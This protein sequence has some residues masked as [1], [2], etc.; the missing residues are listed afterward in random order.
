MREVNGASQYKKMVKI[1]SVAVAL[2]IVVFFALY[3]NGAIGTTAENIWKDARVSQK[4]DIDWL[5]SMST[6]ENM[7]AM[8]FYSEQLDDYT[9]SI[10]LNRPGLS[11]GYFFRS[12]GSNGAIEDSIAEFHI[13]GCTDLAFISMNKQQVCKAEYDYDNG[14]GETLAGTYYIDSM[15]P[16]S[17]ILP[18]K[19]NYVFYNIDGNVVYTIRQEE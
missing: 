1:L 18:N 19:Y 11:F 15:K 13:E 6:S 12:G 2:L 5:T 16:F 10:Y 17:A 9:Y 4:I 3:S 14:A 8:I 7:S